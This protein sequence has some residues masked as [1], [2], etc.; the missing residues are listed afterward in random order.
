MKDFVFADGTHIPAGE[1]VSFAGFAAH[2]D[3]V[4]RMKG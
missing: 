1:Q 3:A 2:R 4:S